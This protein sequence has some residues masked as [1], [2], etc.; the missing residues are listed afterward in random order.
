M[1]ETSQEEL[2]ESH[3]YGSPASQLKNSENCTY[4]IHR[5][6]TLKRAINRKD[7]MISRLT[8]SLHQQNENLRKFLNPDQCLFLQNC[9][10]NGIRWSNETITKALKIRLSCGSKGYQVVAQLGQPLPSERTL[11]RHFQHLKF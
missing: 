6:A 4:Y 1:P 7:K 11:Q 9:V 8:K 3:T 2:M 10:G 5:I